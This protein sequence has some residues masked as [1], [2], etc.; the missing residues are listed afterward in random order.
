MPAGIAVDVDKLKGLMARRRPGQLLSTAR[1]E[2]DE[3]V[4]TEG[5]CESVTTGGRLTV[6]IKNENVRSDDYRK[7]RGLPRPG[8]ADLPA[9]KKHGPDFDMSGGGEF[10]GRMTAPLT[11]VGGVA[12][13]YLESLGIRIAAHLYSVGSVKDLPLNDIRPDEAELSRLSEGFPMVSATAGASA[14]ELIKSVRTA[15]DSIGAVVECAVY[16]MPA[17]VGGAGFEGIDGL[18][19]FFEYAIPGVKGVELGSGFSCAEHKGSEVNDPIVNI[20][21]RVM[22][23]SNHCGG[24]LGGMTTGSP[25]VFRVAFKPTPSIAIKQKTVN[26]HTLDPTEISVGGRHDACIALRAVP[27][28]EAMAALAVLDCLLN[29]KGDGIA[30]KRSRIDVLDAKIAAALDERFSL[31]EEI[32]RLKKENGIPVY[33]P[34]REGELLARIESLSER[35][36]ERIRKIYTELLRQSRAGQEELSNGK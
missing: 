1:S 29:G 20:N 8:H 33:D 11:A 7:L 26:M 23:E 31:T 15:G 32:G 5:L 17:G 13:Q 18:I 25:I 2:A 14:R 24:V 34:V 36:G 30:E 12:L 3:P 9:Y 22:T 27:V 21:G 4:F 16:G 28:V 10:S 6:V 35:N 19:S